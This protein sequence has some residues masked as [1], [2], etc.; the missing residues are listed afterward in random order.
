MT[1]I[2]LKYD[3][4]DIDRMF[5]PVANKQDAEDG[6]VRPGTEAD[7]VAARVLHVDQS[8][9]SWHCPSVF[10]IRYGSSYVATATAPNGDRVR[11]HV[12]DG[13][14]IEGDDDE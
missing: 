2:D 13:D 3:L 7:A 9:L 4:F 8:E 1:I 12:T 14:F 6:A 10:S 11:F 5:P